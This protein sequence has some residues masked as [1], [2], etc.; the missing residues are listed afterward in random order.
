MKTIILAS[1]VGAV[2]VSAFAQGTLNFANAS[3]GFQAKVTDSDG[4]T[5][6]SGSAWSADLYWAPGTVT[7]STLLTAL[8]QPTTFSTVPLQAG[9]FFGG[10]RTIPT[11]PDVPIT[12][13]VRV[14]DTASGNS[15]AAAAA[16]PGARV[17]ESILFQISL[18]NPNGGGFN[19]LPEFPA[20]MT[21][22]NGH[23]WSVSVVPEPS[24]LALAGLGLAGI[25]VLR[26][27]CARHVVLN[28]PAAANLASTLRCHAESQR[29][30]VAGREC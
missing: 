18:G 9:Y 17:G 19:G 23:P 14:W 1:A 8:N 5:G 22:L 7:D 20:S 15:W 30:E 29:R 25:L 16:T 11:Q 24:T 10:V 13:Q 27:T 2:C 3:V 4:V 26:P 28:Y 12:V 21:G 6:L